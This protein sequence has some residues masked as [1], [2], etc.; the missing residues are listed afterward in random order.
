MIEE[1]G[2]TTYSAE[3]DKL[4]F[5]PNARLGTDI[6]GKFRSLG[7]TWA[8][9]QGLFVQVWSPA[10][11]ELCLD[12]SVMIEE[13][14]MSMAERADARSERYATYSENAAQRA[15]Q[16]RDRL[17]AITENIPLGQPILV[18][19]HSERRARKD[20]EKVHA[21]AQAQVDELERADY[22][23][24][25]AKRT[26][27]HANYL[28]RSDVRYRRIKGLEAD[29]RKYQKEIGS[30][31]SYWMRWQL[32]TKGIT[33]EAL[34]EAEISQAKERHVRHYEQWIAHVQGRLVYER[35]LYDDQPTGADK[36]AKPLEVGGMVYC[37]RFPMRHPGWVEIL[38]VNKYKGEVR[39]VTVPSQKDWSQYPDK[40]SFE[41]IEDILTA[42][43][44]SACDH[45]PDSKPIKPQVWQP[46]E[47]KPELTEAKAALNAAQQT[48]VVIGG[49]EL[50]PTPM[51][52]VNQMLV[53]AQTWR[54]EPMLIL[55]PSAGDG[56]IAMAINKSSPQHTVHCVELDFASC[57]VMRNAGLNVQQGDFLEYAPEVMY[58]AVIMNPP[59]SQ[60]RD[61]A[62]V[63][64]AW[65]LLKPGGVLV[66]LI[67][68]HA[69][70]AQD[71]D[72]LSFTDWMISV[73]C[74]NFKLPGNTFK[75]SGTMVQARMIW[76]TRE[77]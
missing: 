16:A 23:S 60:R 75:E 48:Q 22:W 45:K 14:D 57:Q 13:E 19:H 21:A 24:D 1:L 42:S 63:R 31:D 71:K 74:Q 35:A 15:G 76:T 49:M 26:K 8:P 62:H 52:V 30:F 41:D 59:Y 25:R 9:R 43:E 67:S 34:I 5:T 72:S 33:D 17:D 27:M 20:A 38:K 11:E 51:K 56:R 32:E 36:V 37:K 77:G 65:E 69:F 46:R 29:L 55:E 4:R 3:D 68:E 66:A 7:F 64:H 61:I 39:S 70:F 2:T 73:N 54:D 53:K 12:Y 40:V 6:F 44:A 50:Y 18:G 10:R 28:S 58:D 47:E